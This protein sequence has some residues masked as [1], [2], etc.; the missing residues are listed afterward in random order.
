MPKIPVNVDNLATELEPLDEGIMYAGIC[1]ACKLADETDKNGNSYL[2]GIRI[3]ILEPEQFRG[4]AAFVNYM[5]IPQSAAPPTTELELQFGRFVKAFKIPHDAEGF[6]P[7]DAVGCEGQF[8]VQ[9]EEY[10][11]RKSSRVKDWLL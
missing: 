2:T 11:G 6:D 4:R 5:M 7:D 3:D 8:T 1:R 9:T 10:Q